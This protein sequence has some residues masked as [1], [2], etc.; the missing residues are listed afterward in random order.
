MGTCCDRKNC[1]NKCSGHGS[2]AGTDGTCECVYGYT[3][4]DC[5]VQAACPMNQI[6]NEACSGVGVCKPSAKGVFQ[7]RT[8]I[9]P[10]SKTGAACQRDL[11]PF[12][13]C[14]NGKRGKCVKGQCVCNPGYGGIGCQQQLFMP[15]Q[16]AQSCH[17]Q[18]M[19]MPDCFHPDA[20]SK[21]IASDVSAATKY[22]LRGGGDYEEMLETSAK[23]QSSKQFSCFYNCL[24]NCSKKN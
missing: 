9:C 7:V 6:T 5:S 24:I 2:C 15:T 23:V 21:A 12:N 1:P 22:S 11:C 13:D 17:S 8:C 4:K 20:A 10:T 18:C 3:G 16:C 19:S 14:F